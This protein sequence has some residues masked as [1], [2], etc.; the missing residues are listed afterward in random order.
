MLLQMKGIVKTF[1][2]VKALSD[3]SFDMEMGEVHVLLGENGAGKSTLIKILSGAYQRDAGEILLDGNPVE[4]K[5]PAVARELGI[6]TTYQELDL[7]QTLT[8]AENITM[9]TR[10]AGKLMVNWNRMN[11]FVEDILKRLG[12]DLSPTDIVGDLTVGEQQLVAIAKA[13]SSNV[14]IL[15]LDEPTSAL[16][17]KEIETFFKAIRRL[18]EQNVGIIY[19][20]HRMNEIFEIGDRVTV[21]R[22]GRWIATEKIC[23]ATPDQLVKWIAG[24]ELRELYPP[25]SR[26]AYGGVALEVKDLTLDKHLNHVNF[27]VH[28][29]EIVGLFGQIGSGASELALCLI[30]AMTPTSGEIMVNGKTE[31]I[32]TPGQAVRKGISLLPEDRRRQGLCLPLSIRFNIAL[33]SMKKNSHLIVDDKRLNIKSEELSAKMGIKAPNLEF[34]TRNLSGGNQQKV[35]IAKWLVYGAEVLI[36]SEPTRG[37]DVGSRSEI[38]KLMASLADEGKAILVISS[39]L[40]EVL[41][42]SHRIH[43]INKGALVGEFTHEEAQ[44]DAVLSLAMA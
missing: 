4:L 26:K 22:D 2:G 19:I 7:A 5:S 37:I 21:F 24:R 12:I 40:N 10:Q 30:R 3:V 16:T 32:K 18:Q 44:N 41:G 43:V 6:F 9:G 36:F 15:I 20:T 23:D 33:P 14:R 25:I 29:G 31:D 28:K 17:A 38:Y 39:D 13:L 11:S 27:E 42:I 8:V 35:V 34:I 1:P